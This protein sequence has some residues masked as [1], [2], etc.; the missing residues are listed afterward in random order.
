MFVH[1]YNNHDDATYLLRRL[2]PYEVMDADKFARLIGNHLDCELYEA[3][4]A[5]GGADITVEF[6]RT[7]QR[8]AVCWSTTEFYVA[9]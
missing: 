6:R 3:N 8:N 2:G 7:K 9:Q 1:V 4:G 5:Y